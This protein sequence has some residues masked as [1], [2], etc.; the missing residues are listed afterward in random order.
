MPLAGWCDVDNSWV[1]VN[2]DG[3]CINGHGQEHVT[4][5]YDTDTQNAP[6]PAPPQQTY[7]PV[8]SAAPQQGY[9]PG[10]PVPPVSYGPPPGQIAQTGPSSNRPTLSIVFGIASILCCFP[11][12]TIPAAVAGIIFGVQGLK[13]EKRTL[14]I[15]GIVLSVIGL[16]GSLINAI[17]GAYFAVSD[18]E[19]LENLMNTPR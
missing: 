6:P 3:S 1:W 4:R 17:L 19:F 8:P 14:A 10:A 11:I 18:P 12:V 7:A 16:I 2:E 5:V 9:A 13:T 15:V